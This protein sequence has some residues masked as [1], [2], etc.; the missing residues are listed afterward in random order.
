MTIMIKQVRYNFLI[1]NKSLLSIL[2][3]FNRKNNKINALD[4]TLG[5]YNKR[6]NVVEWTGMSLRQFIFD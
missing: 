3:H 6:T 2:R 4:K 1:L 5:Y